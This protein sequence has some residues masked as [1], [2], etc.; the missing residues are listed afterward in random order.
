VRIRFSERADKDYAGLPPYVRKAFAK[1]LDYLLANPRHPS[2]RAKKF[3]AS[4]NLWQA[5]VDRNWRFY[6]KIEGD[7]YAIFAI[8][9]HP[10]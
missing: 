8:I 3:D 10:K 2:L 4:D 1:Q 9:P 5:R 6:F 7:E